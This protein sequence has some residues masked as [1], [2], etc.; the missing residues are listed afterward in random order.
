MSG[1]TVSVPD[2]CVL[3]VSMGDSGESDVLVV[4]AGPSGLFAAAELARHGV[5][6]QVVE[7]SRFPH[8][9]ARAT[10][11]Q[12]AT[13]E[14]LQQAGL[15]D[16]VLSSSEHLGCARLFDANL[17]CVTELAFAGVGCPWEFQ[18]SLPQWRT[19]EI[20]AGRLA[21]LGGSVQRGVTVRSLTERS[22]S[23]LVELEEA[24]GTVR[25]VEAAWVI[26]A[27][28]AHSITRESMD[29]ELAGSTYAGSGLAG[30][31]GVS[32]GLPRDGSALIASP[33]GYVLLAPLPGERWLTFIGDLSDDEAELLARDRSRDRVGAAIGR[34][35][36]GTLLT[37]NDVSWA[38]IFQLHRRLAPRLADTRRFLLG[39]AGHLS[40]PWGGEGL[41]SGL[42]DGHNLAWKLALYQHGHARPGLVGSFASER[43]TADRHVLEVSDRLHQLAHA[44]VEAARAGAFPAPPPPDDVRR[45]AVSRS[46]LDVSYEG[47]PLVGEY[48][49][50]G[51]LALPFPAPGSRYPDRTSLSGTGHQLLLFGTPADSDVAYLRRRWNGIVD[52]VVGRGSPRL[53]GLAGE[54]AIL[55]RPDGY[56]GFRAAPADHAGLSAVDSHL[57]SYLVPAAA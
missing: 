42:H 27:G 14:I 29:E 37:L 46:M 32:C 2:G 21:E 18:C 23:V 31:V 30:E 44:S 47:S 5:R 57:N 51:G 33:A 19:E 35:I 36:P 34:R 40:S 38:S 43:M 55:V 4:G 7:R 25:S 54:A 41:N 13:L 26:G 28:G 12:P 48:L 11:L 45:M 8:H 22:D 16:Q 39:D 3:M 50:P 1:L 53:A 15:V 56:I 24:D 10:A 52:V 6:A 20:L 49:G 9:Q 17:R